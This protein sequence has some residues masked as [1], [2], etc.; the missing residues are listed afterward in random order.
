MDLAC[1][2]NHPLLLH[3]YSLTVTPLGIRKN[4]TA[5]GFI[6]C[7]CPVLPIHEDGVVEFRKEVGKH[8]RGHLAH[9]DVAEV[10]RGEQ[11]GTDRLAHRVDDL[12]QGQHLEFVVS[13]AESPLSRPFHLLVDFGEYLDGMELEFLLATLARFGVSTSFDM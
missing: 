7:T 13:Q 9:E 1:V 3:T 10:V 2:L 4:V 6:R 12:R 8:E 11:L 5:D